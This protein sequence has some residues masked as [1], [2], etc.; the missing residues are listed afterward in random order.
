M[1]SS[2]PPLPISYTPVAKRRTIGRIALFLPSLRGGGA[3][4][5]MVQLANGL[6]RGGHPVD[7]LLPQAEGPYLSLVVPEVRIVDLAARRVI[8]SLPALW[9][10]LRR[11][12]PVALLATLSHANLLALWAK[13]LARV[14]TRVVVREANTITAG[15]QSATGLTDRMLPWLAR[16]FYPWADAIVAVSEGV[17]SDLVDG[18]GIP[19]EKVHVLY[20][21]LV[22]AELRAMAQA[23]VEHEWFHDGTRPVILGVGRLSRQKDFATLLRAFGQLRARRAARL[24]ILGEG[25]ERPQLQALVTELGLESDVWMPGFVDNPFKYM[26]RAGVFVLSSAFEGSPGVLVQALACGAPVVATDC[27]SGPREILE[28][29]RW[30]RLVPVGDASAMSQA[31]E[32]ALNGDP[33]LAPESALARFTPEAAI[34]GY[35]AL[36]R[37]GRNG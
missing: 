9:R 10:Y 2:A 4:R 36:L 8:S 13:R 22:T 17:A 25:D 34:E 30:G 15:S 37:V 27:P 3:E 26:A 21:P 35:L 31:L 6:S 5:V 23:P 33:R 20:N 14:A 7:L 28:G 11:E 19:R 18:I 29:E 24:V 12:R 32:S 16:Q 1:R